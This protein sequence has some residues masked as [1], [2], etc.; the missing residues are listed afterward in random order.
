MRTFLN[1]RAEYAIEDMQD[2]LGVSKN[3]ATITVTK[4]GMG[5]LSV[6]NEDTAFSGNVWTGSFEDGKKVTI[7]AKP[8]EGYVF[9][10]WSGTSSSDSTTITV[11]AE[12]ATMLVCIFRKTE[13]EQG[14]IN[15]DGAVNAA[16]LLLMTKYICGVDNFTKTQFNLADMN[17]DKAADIFDLVRLRKE[18]L[19]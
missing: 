15:M 4:R 2:Y 16:D 10:G 13:Y 18:L 8:A 12:N 6:N 7:T 14:D 17:A 19:K 1:R 9:E 3:S 11:T 5:E